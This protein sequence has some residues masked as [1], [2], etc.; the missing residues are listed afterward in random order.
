MALFTT[1]PFAVLSIFLMHTGSRHITFEL[2]DAQKKILAHPV[3]KL[4]ILTAMFY[5]G[6][7][8]VV[9]SLTLLML[10]YLLVNM[11]LNENH[12]L[13]VFS[14]GWLMANGYIDAH[15]T[16]Q[17]YKDMYKKNVEALSR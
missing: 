12:S 13:N 4:I 15:A 17:N 10:Y 6:T 3:S 7:R 5:V 14:P 1:D 9:W 8:S 16:D 2:T 11:L